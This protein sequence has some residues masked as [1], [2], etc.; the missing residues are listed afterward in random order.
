M[1]RGAN[2]AAPVGFVL[3]MLS[4]AVRPA[5]YVKTFYHGINLPGATFGS[6]HIPG[7][8]KKDYSWPTAADVKLYADMGANIVRVAFLWERMQPQL[9]MSLEN[10]EVTRL[11][12]VVAA[13]AK[14]HVTILLDVHN[15]GLYKKQPIGSEAVPVTAFTD[16]WGRLA[17]HYKGEPFVAFG[18]MNE[19]YQH[20]ADEWAQIV[21]QAI[22]EIRHEGANQLILVSGTHWSGAHS[23]M[24]KDGTLSNAEAL[25]DL[26]D[27]E[28]NFAFEAHQY[29]D[30]DSSGTHPEC[31][32]DDIGEQRLSA[33]TAWLRQNDK[34][35]F[36]GEFGASK[37]PVCVEALRRGLKYL[38]DNKDVWYG[39][40]YW[41]AAAWFGNY[42][43]NIY[44]PDPKRFPQVEILTDAM[45][46]FEN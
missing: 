19:P 14:L 27:P 15:Y 23:W 33:M 39:W 40:T 26:T 16:L 38:V 4:T 12:A 13:A 10:Y 31:V 34:R 8:D 30:V 21:Q 43:F 18:L 29:F 17:A 6:Q 1:R 37:D 45:R 32:S 35:G 9:F 3:F 36:L 22:N 41:A 42:M 25:A 46:G 44:P 5:E 7:V 2:I 11:D 24:A 28:N 20:K